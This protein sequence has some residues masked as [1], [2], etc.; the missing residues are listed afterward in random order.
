MLVHP[1][2]FG[3]AKHPDRDRDQ[4]CRCQFDIPIN[5]QIPLKKGTFLK[6]RGVL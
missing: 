4:N 5:S 3:V 1:H 2:A 6:G